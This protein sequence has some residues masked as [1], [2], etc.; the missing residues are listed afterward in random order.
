MDPANGLRADC[1]ANGGRRSHVTCK[2]LTAAVLGV[3]AVV[4][5][6]T[7]FQALKDGKQS[8][9]S[10]SA[11]PAAT[12]HGFIS[13]AQVDSNARTFLCV[14][15]LRTSYAAQIPVNVCTYLVYT[16]VYFNQRADSFSPVNEA[17]LSAFENASLSGA[18]VLAAV[19]SPS[20]P[21][22]AQSAS[23]VRRVGEAAVRWLVARAFRGLAFV[24][25]RTTTD[26]LEE[27]A[28][29]V[30]ELQSTLSASRLEIALSVSLTDWKSPRAL[31]ATRLYSI[32]QHVNLLVLQTHYFL[33]EPKCKTGFPTVFSATPDEP[34]TVPITNALGWINALKEDFRVRASVCF[35][36]SL[37][38]Y[39]FAGA[40]AIPSEC[41]SVHQRAY[42]MVCDGKQWEKILP[43]NPHGGAAISR[44]ND[45]LLSYEEAAV[46][47]K[48]VNT[49]VQ[50]TPSAC[51]AVF[52]VDMDD[53]E[54]VCGAPFAR[55]QSLLQAESLGESAEEELNRTTTAAGSEVQVHSPPSRC[56][57]Q[58]GDRRPLLCILSERTDRKRT[59]SRQL[60][61]HFVFSLRHMEYAAALRVLSSELVEDFKG[62]DAPLLVALDERALDSVPSHEFAHQTSAQLRR[63]GLHG[64]ALLY[65]AVPLVNAATLLPALVVLHTTY[66]EDNLCL[67]FSAQVLAD[68]DDSAIS[69]PSIKQI[70]RFTDMFILNTHYAGY[71]GP[72]RVIA[73]STL[74]EDRKSCIPTLPVETAAEWLKQVEES[75][76][77]GPALFVSVDM[78]SFRYRVY[79]RPALEASCNL[80]EHAEFIQVCNNTGWRE[81]H[82]RATAA[83]VKVKGNDVVSY[84][85]PESVKVTALSVRRAVQHGSVAVFNADFEDWQGSCLGKPYPRLEALRNALDSTDVGP[86]VT[87]EPN[88]GNRSRDLVSEE[89]DTRIGR[90]LLCVV[91]GELYDDSQVPD[92]LC[93]HIVHPG[94]SVDLTERTV[95]LSERSLRL[96]WSRKHARHL[97]ALAGGG[98]SAVV[99]N[100]EGSGPRTAAYV[101][102]QAA[103]FLRRH[104]LHGLALLNL[105]RTT[106]GLVKFAQIVHAM[107]SVFQPDLQIMLS[108]EIVDIHVPP[109]LLAK[110]LR[111]LVKEVD[112]LVFETHFYHSRGYC[113]KVAPSSYEAPRKAFTVSM[114]TALSW[115]E[116]LNQN[117]SICLSVNL[118]VLQFTSAG[119]RPTCER[120]GDV[121]YSETCDS[122]D[123]KIMLS[124]L[125]DSMVRRKE[126]IWQSY[127]EPKLLKEKVS[128][129][130][131]RQPAA[132]MAAFNIDYDDYKPACGNASFPRLAAIED[133]YN[134]A[135]GNASDVRVLRNSLHEEN[136]IQ[137]IFRMTG[138]LNYRRRRP[139]GA[140]QIFGNAE[141]EAHGNNTNS[142]VTHRPFVCFLSSSWSQLHALPRRHCT[143]YVFDPDGADAP[144]T[145]PALNV[146]D[147]KE[148][149]G[150]GR[151]FL[152][153]VH[154]SFDGNE[155]T[156]IGIAKRLTF[157]G[158]DGVAI[159][160]QKYLSTEFSSLAVFVRL[161][162]RKL[163]SHSSVLLGVEI[164]DY[165]EDPAVIVQ[166]LGMLFS[167]SEIVILQTHFMRSWAFCKTAYPSVYLDIGDGC[168]QTV[169]MK[170]ALGW[171]LATTERGAACLSVT[172][173]TQAF[174]VPGPRPVGTACL[175][176]AEKRPVCGKGGSETQDDRYGAAYRYVDEEWLSY[177][178]EHLLSMKMRAAR[179]SHPSFCVAVFNADY[180]APD[181]SCS[182]KR[183]PPPFSRLDA[184]ADG[185]GYK[186]AKEDERKGEPPTIV[187][188][189][190]DDER[191]VPYMPEEGCDFLV[192]QSIVYKNNDTFVPRSNKTDF[193]RRFASTSTRDEETKYLV[194]LDAGEFVRHY[195]SEVRT[196]AWFT[197]FVGRLV[198]FLEE[199][200]IDG[201]AL[202]E[203][204]LSLA[205]L[206]R[207]TPSLE[208]IRR[209]TAHFGYTYLL[210]VT[211]RESGNI[212]IA[213]A[214]PRLIALSRLAD[215]LVLESHLVAA[216]S[217]A[218]NGSCAVRFPSSAHAS[219]LSGGHGLSLDEAARFLRRLEHALAISSPSS[220]SDGDEEHEDTEGQ[221]C[222]SISLAAFRFRFEGAANS[223]PGLACKSVDMVPFQETCASSH[224]VSWS[225]VKVS[226][227]ERSSYRVAPGTVIT[228]DTVDDIE[229][230]LVGP[231]S[232][233]AHHVLV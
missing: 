156:F 33:E 38:V 30:E 130:I 98:S 150:A 146:S 158:L 218:E 29:V 160:E 23:L 77:Q 162:K 126:T 232:S 138:F 140:K 229:H 187:C 113:Q 131:S 96:A 90:P 16:D 225:A 65:V 128:K 145:L 194:A 112:I 109:K 8:N 21:E 34:Q 182:K 13:E 73:A 175:T 70:A 163:P 53:Y 203:L 106:R 5:S 197:R 114:R 195:A 170:T 84:E 155:E 152:M 101:A 122:R 56:A 102:L 94:L 40:S 61:T 228:F 10:D 188:V 103:G 100:L 207:V 41:K 108:V 2:A 47:A 161:L 219:T 27:L 121:S 174:R 227:A 185:A 136:A 4:S 49:A 66:R 80:E 28:G 63:Y 107:R 198:L 159:A 20:L 50:K 116:A 69:V 54:G 32:A 6:I 31:V 165:D 46:G 210:G 91:S 117:Q 183:A 68:A 12:R 92:R 212:T 104:A 199:N 214:L 213:A 176:S 75:S 51:V 11:A 153:R 105:D 17:T 206:D 118:A 110:R 151:K 52:D 223:V 202:V 44:S 221:L 97:A 149:V 181:V 173:A 76:P 26:K 216:S 169:P 135:D 9:G 60:C 200:N 133:A 230:K 196:E 157:L 55:L 18:R 208:A 125:S 142:N 209:Y 82:I 58:K 7:A 89:D 64:L 144:R 14:S 211:L 178:T 177:E 184:I 123:W 19:G 192:Y 93:T 36:V 147:I 167:L 59:V 35:S 85:T 43:S 143:H 119:D 95:F 3:T 78:R 81:L 148:Y 72:C 24:N 137:D 111:D 204:P 217:R 171:A 71:M 42:D 120:R 164:Q 166:R 129:V 191:D 168:S 222:F 205:E 39:V 172:M 74:Q 139:L 25:Y 180:D 48:K 15:S 22:L 220:S 88:I 62:V 87:P 132:C 115:M 226:E 86:P 141:P 37:G 215:V 193:F 1:P 233:H 190:S 127:E 124:N 179:R 186:K 57:A 134:Q 154:P 99:A 231:R 201:V 224:N 79:Q 67:A 189:V 83:A 45:E